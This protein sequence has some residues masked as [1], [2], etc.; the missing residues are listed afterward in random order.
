MRLGR[1]AL[2]VC[3]C[4]QVQ[5]RVAKSGCMPAQA[6]VATVL[7]DARL[8]VIPAVELVPGDIVEI[9]G[10]HACIFSGAAVCCDWQHPL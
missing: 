4:L 10:V 6:D 8:S 5:R 7:R 3:A 9:A 1:S 2:L